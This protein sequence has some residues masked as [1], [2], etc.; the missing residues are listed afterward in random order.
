MVD[1]KTGLKPKAKKTEVNAKK[2][3]I[4][5][6]DEIKPE[7]EKVVEEA[8]AIEEP[9]V[10]AKA[11]RRSAKAIRE[12]EAEKARQERKQAAAAAEV[13]DEIPKVIQKPPRSRLERA[14]KKYRQA[15]KLI[16]KARLYT[17]AEALDLAVKTSTTKFDASIE[18]HVNLNV[19]PKQADQNVR[20]SLTLPSGTGRTTRVAVFTDGDGV[21]KAKAAGADIAG[22]EDLLAKLDKEEVNF[23]VLITSPNL[24]PRLGKY[25]KLLGPKGLMPNPKSGT[26]SAD[27]P[28]AVK[29]AKAGRVEYR[30]DQAGIIHLGIGKVSFG[31]DKLRQNADAVLASIKAAKPS[32]LKGAYISS[33]YVTTTMG[34]S[35]KVAL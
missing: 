25:A 2:P 28:K 17:V 12:V 21:T 30:V 4:T 27:I 5:K 33:A 20:D 8:T 13:K 15:A 18:I 24:M 23:D 19:D 16:D 6:K 32:S 1:K 34:P 31:P 26:I 35:I 29:E 10:K 9:N 14:G 22:N 3:K 7:L 11:G